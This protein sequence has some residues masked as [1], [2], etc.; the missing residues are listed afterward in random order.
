M[1]N[2]LSPSGTATAFKP[3]I[4]LA[5]P[6]PGQI[7]SA[8]NVRQYLHSEKYPSEIAESHSNCGKVQDAYSLRCTPQVGHIH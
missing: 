6:H 5:R 7:L 3:E 4:Q 1:T 2:V 8:Q